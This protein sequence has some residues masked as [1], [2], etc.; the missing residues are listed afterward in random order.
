MMCLPFR[1]FIS[2]APRMA[3]LSLSE[4]QEVKHSSS[5]PQP[6]ALASSPRQPFTRSAACL[7]RTYWEEGLPQPSVMASSAAWAASGRTGVV[8]A[9]SK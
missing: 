3:Q 8:A 2:S 5:G 7:P 1:R 4:P 6:R 9:L